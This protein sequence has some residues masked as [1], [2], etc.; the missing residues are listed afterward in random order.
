MT[1]DKKGREHHNEPFPHMICLCV[2]CYTDV[3]LLVLARR[4]NNTAGLDSAILKAMLDRG[5][6]QATLDWSKT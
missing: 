4:K 1:I 3:E 6:I 5:M 2:G